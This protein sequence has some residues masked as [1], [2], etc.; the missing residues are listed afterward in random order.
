MGKLMIALRSFL[1]WRANLRRPL[2]VRLTFPPFLTSYYSQQVV[3]RR[4]DE[5]KM[6]S[7][8]ARDPAEPE[9]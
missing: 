7:I 5:W 2:F 9:G 8:D 6:K 3:D 1:Y 4:T